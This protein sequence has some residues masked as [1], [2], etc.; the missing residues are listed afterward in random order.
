MLP[1]EGKHGVVVSKVPVMQAGLGGVMTRHF[2]DYEMTYCRSIQELTLLQL[3]R[4]GVI[5][6]DISGDYRNPRGTL[7][8]YYGLL[9]QYRD[10]HWIFLVS[11]P[12][13]PLAIELLMRPESTLLSDMEPIEGVIS[14]IRAGS[15][16]AERIS[17]TLLMPES[18]DLD[19]ETENFIALTHS[20]RKV[21]RLLGKGWGINQIATL[22]KKS[23]KT[24]SA[25]KN[26]AMR[27]LSL[28]SNADMYA[29]I[30]STQ[31]MRELSL[32]SA[33]GDFDEW[34]R[35]LQQDISPSLKIAQ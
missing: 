6:A 1:S 34:K 32:M 4:A 19:E 22:L 14:A 28:R 8:Q 9:N 16:R 13:Y 27:R 5:I 24:I 11:R 7:E 2:P 26:S 3:R 20:E 23:N 12:L 35:P 33:Y 17:Q 31:G 29:W 10:V 18:P 15:E 25:Q 30:S 21:L